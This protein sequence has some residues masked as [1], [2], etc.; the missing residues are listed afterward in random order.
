[1]PPT[2]PTPRLCATCSSIVGHTELDVNEINHSLLTKSKRS[3]F[4]MFPDEEKT[5]AFEKYKSKLGF[6]DVFAK[7]RLEILFDSK[8]FLTSPFE[9]IF[10]QVELE[11]V[12]KRKMYDSIIDTMVIESIFDNLKDYNITKMLALDYMKE[13]KE[14]V[15]HV[16]FIMGLYGPPEYQDIVEYVKKEFMLASENMQNQLMKIN[17]INTRQKAIERMMDDKDAREKAR[18]MIKRV[19]DNAR[20]MQSAKI[21]AALPAEQKTENQQFV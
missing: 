11:D 9:N 8:E 14:V 17:D 12:K 10:R 3:L 1:M 21:N 2:A 6:T 4:A 19:A 16:G 20:D 5:K 13:N 18:E 15:K 7:D